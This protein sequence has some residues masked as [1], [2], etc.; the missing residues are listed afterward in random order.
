MPVILIGNNSL[1]NFL[2]KNDFLGLMIFKEYISL[3]KYR[4]FRM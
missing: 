4:V 1:L 3:I 2:D